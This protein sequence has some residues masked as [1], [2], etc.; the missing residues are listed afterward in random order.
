M[1][2]SEPARL[3][4]LREYGVLDT[5]PEAA[6]DRITELA[7]ELF[8]APIALV[9]LVDA[10]RQWFKSAIGLPVS[11]TPR[12]YAFCDHTIR[13]DEVMVVP[14][15]TADDRFRDNPLVLDDPLI[16]FYAGAPLTLPSGLRIGS[17]CV[18]DRQPRP[19]LSEKDRRRLAILA[20][21]VVGELN[22]R[23]ANQRLDQARKVAEAAAEARS[24]FLANMSHEL[25]TPLTSIIGYSGILAA[26]QT[27]PERERHFV[28]RINSASQA[29]LAIVNDVLDLTRLDSGAEDEPPEKAD[30]R[31]I[32]ET[33]LGIVAEQARAKGL[34]LRLEAPGALPELHVPTARLRQ[35]LLNLLSNA[36]KFTETGHVTLSLA[37]DERRFT[38][39]VA[40]TGVG[41]AKDRQAEVFDRFVQAD[42]SVAKKYG[43]TGLG[44]TI[45]RR[46]AERMGGELSVEST[47]GEGSVFTLALPL[48]LAPA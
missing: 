16:R 38:I 21:A 20:A 33:A 18:I 35:I 27:L 30:I 5:P 44:L 15:A 37:A 7:A 8:D 17:L 28:Q 6:F 13:T 12:A 31:Q 48:V 24:E 23:L 14:D 9:S 29:L 19:P 34:D 39:R 43:G 2:P 26:A 46:L 3:Q 11:E 1:S 42:S 36:V 10:D 22:L 32:A 45:S 41:I 4:A 47:P 40:D 25:R